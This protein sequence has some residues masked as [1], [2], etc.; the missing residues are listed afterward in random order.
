[1]AEKNNPEEPLKNKNNKETDEC[2]NPE[3]YKDNKEPIQYNIQ[4]PFQITKNLIKIIF[5]SLTKIISKEIIFQI[6]SKIII[7]RNYILI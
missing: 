3:T 6:L 1:M 5:Q 4:K 2:V 7:Q